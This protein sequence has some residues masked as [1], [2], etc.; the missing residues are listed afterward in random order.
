MLSPVM[1]SRGLT[2]RGA[3]ALVLGIFALILPG[4]MLVGLT[5]L[6]AGYLLVNGI[7]AL[8][9]ALKK[10]VEGR[11]WLFLEAAV[12]IFAGFAIFLRP[13]S[14]AFSLIYLIGLWAVFT[15]AVQI[16]EGFVLRRHIQHEGAYIFSGVLTL[17][18][19][20]VIL[21]GP[22]IG[23]RAIAAMIG[24]YGIM[25]GISSLTSARHVKVLEESTVETEQRR[26]A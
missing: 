13:L 19:G 4:P 26:A 9:S 10:G 3:A 24:I 22:R 20:F 2:S 15:G 1:S 25:F 6:I 17:L 12:C 23:L 14:S 7:S 18:F 5:F 16:V 11:G 8:A 21:S